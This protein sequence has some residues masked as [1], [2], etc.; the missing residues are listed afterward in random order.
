M[1]FSQ[2]SQSCLLMELKL[3]LAVLFREDFFYNVTR[4]AKLS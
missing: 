1:E 3:K 2:H 4:P